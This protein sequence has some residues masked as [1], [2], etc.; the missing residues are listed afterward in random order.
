MLAPVNKL[1]LRTLRLWERWSLGEKLALPTLA[2]YLGFIDMQ[3]FNHVCEGVY[4]ERL[5]HELNKPHGS[6]RSL[7]EQMAI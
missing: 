2:A 6:A 7:A 5:N 1:A 3:T 4:N